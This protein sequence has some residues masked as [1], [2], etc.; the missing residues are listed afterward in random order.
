MFAALAIAFGLLTVS[1]PSPVPRDTPPDA[2]VVGADAEETPEGYVVTLESL[3]GR[4]DVDLGKLHVDLLGSDGSL[5]A[6]NLARRAIAGT[7]YAYPDYPKNV[8]IHVHVRVSRTLLRPGMQMLRF[9]FDRGVATRDGKP[10]EVDENPD[11]PPVRVVV[12]DASGDA[13][14]RGRYVGTTVY[15]Y[16]EA[17]ARCDV[18]GYPAVS[19]AMW[20][21]V[22]LHVTR[23]RRAAGTASVVRLGSAQ[24]TGNLRP[25]AY[26]VVD[27]LEVDFAGSRT[28]AIVAVSGPRFDAGTTAR[29]RLEAAQ[30][31]MNAA[32]KGGCRSLHATF[33]GA[34]DL[35]RAFASRA[36]PT[37]ESKVRIGMTH[38]QVAY[39]LGFPP[40]FSPKEQLLR[41]PR[42][43][44]AG[45]PVNRFVN[46]RGDRVSS[47]RADLLM[48]FEPFKPFQ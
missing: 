37:E 48:P 26:K 13:A 43:R 40:L 4:F 36:P 47:Y 27:P 35:E 2:V 9:R 45:P 10:V 38:E 12:P 24:V 14:L 32:W 44:Y 29:S 34:W 39:L 25:F 5:R 8:T 16:G 30:Q 28:V 18:R 17:R 19:V 15:A 23:I 7:A 1:L 42:W 21:E 20:P 31:M 33:A 3:G 6:R 41:A 46:F 11:A 22:A